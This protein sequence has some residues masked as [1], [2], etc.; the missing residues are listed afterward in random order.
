MRPAW[1]TSMPSS[2][3]RPVPPRAT[4]SPRGVRACVGPN[5]PYRMPVILPGA[6][7]AVQGCW[8]HPPSRGQFP[9]YG[10]NGAG[11]WWLRADGAEEVAIVSYMTR[12]IT[13]WACTT[14][15]VAP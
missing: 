6:V 10:T 4:V 8:H 3:R 11:V 13:A 15:C 12:P 2:A 9:L 1:T 14:G 7:T 5:T